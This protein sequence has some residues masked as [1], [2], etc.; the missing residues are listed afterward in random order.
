[1]ENEERRTGGQG[2]GVSRFECSAF[3]VRVLIVEC[4]GNISSST[5]YGVTNLV[6]EV[7][8]AVTHEESLTLLRYELRRAGPPSSEAEIQFLK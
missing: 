5:L 7:T 3:I 6:S 1:M 4:F 8:K 2:F